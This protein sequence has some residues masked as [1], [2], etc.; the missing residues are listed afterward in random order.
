MS[1]TSSPTFRGMNASVNADQGGVKF[2][3]HRT[4]RGR[5]CRSSA[6]EHIIMTGAHAGR[7]SVGRQP[8]HF[9][10]AA[11]HPIALDGIADLSRHREA[12][13][14]RSIF[15]STVERLQHECAAGSTHAFRRGLKIASAFQPLDHDGGRAAIRH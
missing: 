6:D 5:E 7:A 8:D 11:A 4:E 2:L 10:Q 12:N 15:F 13:A 1:T 9:A 3:H 14:G